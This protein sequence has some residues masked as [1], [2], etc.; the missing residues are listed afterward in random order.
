MFFDKELIYSKRYPSP[1]EELERLSTRGIQLLLSQK[2]VKESFQSFLSLMNGETRCEPIPG[3][4]EKAQEFITLA[5]EFS[6]EYEIDADIRRVSCSVEVCLHFYCGSYGK[7]MTRQ[8][9]RLFNLCDNL[10]SFVL[11]SEPADFT[12]ILEMRTHKVYRSGVLM[13]DY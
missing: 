6:E 13:N 8:F 12:L 5:R 7:D 3:R 2:E 10:S 4:E 11:K 9:A 1:T